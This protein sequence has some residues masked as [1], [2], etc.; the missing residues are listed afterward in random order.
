MVNLTQQGLVALQDL[1][2]QDILELLQHAA[3]F[4]NGLRKNTLEGKVLASCFFDVLAGTRLS[5]D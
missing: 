2:K 5:F 1:N 3:A 4:K